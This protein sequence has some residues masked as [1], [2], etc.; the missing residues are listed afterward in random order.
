MDF[1]KLLSK[2]R[3]GLLAKDEF[4]FYSSIILGVKHSIDNSAETAYTDGLNCYYNEEFF[5][6]LSK[7]EREFLVAHEGLHIALEHCTSRSAG[8]DPERWND[9]CDYV[10][11]D[12]LIRAG[13]KMPAGGLHDPQYRNMST[14][15][16]YRLLE[17]KD[18]QNNGGGTSG[19][20]QLGG[21]QLRDLKEPPTN[22]QKKREEI[23]QQA[24]D[25]VMRGKT[26][27]EMSGQMPGEL[28]PDLQ[29]ILDRLTKPVIPWQRILQRFFNAMQ[30]NDFTWARPNRRYI[31]QDI[32]LPSMLSPALGPIDFAW[33]TSGSI[34]DKI[35]NY[36]VSETYHVLK[37]F[38]P[39]YVNVM[40]FD[41][42]M[43]SRDKVRN[44]R[45]LLNLEMKGGGGTRVDESIEAFAKSN[46]QA[47]IVLTDG[48]VNTHHI[49][50]PRKPV[51]WCVYHN[52][53]FQPPWGQV[54]HFEMPEE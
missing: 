16:V 17:E 29:R 26:L 42:V 30:K 5:K 31:S 46:S 1:Q 37:R 7:D 51:I 36:F 50:D 12:I 52:K 34:T 40:Q 44:M 35:F 25:L 47:L 41:H 43:R 18:K 11:N 20:N 53:A 33:D 13:L 32:Y 39:E 45:D 9:A 14:L 22:D 48:Y 15:Q 24:E 54:V 23:K 8:M 28:G 6:G 21:K 2:A 3:I 49:P 4:V 10:I 38:K 27:A 19:G